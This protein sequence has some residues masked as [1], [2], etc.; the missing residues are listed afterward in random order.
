MRSCASSS[1]GCRG[2]PSKSFRALKL[3]RILPFLVPGLWIWKQEKPQTEAERRKKP[4]N[5]NGDR[6]ERRKSIF[7]PASNNG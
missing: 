6:E 7:E 1:K 3:E 2:S 5:Q 4:I